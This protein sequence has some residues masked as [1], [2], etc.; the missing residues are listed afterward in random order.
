[1]P[2]LDNL[3]A[4][5]C[6]ASAAD[7]PADQRAALRD[8]GADCAIAFLAGSRSP[9]G[10][11]LMALTDASSNVDKIATATAIIRSTE[12]DDI[13][14]G[15]CT[16]PSSVAVPAAI[17]LSGD[18]ESGEAWSDVESAVLVGIETMVRFGLAINGP[19]ILY[20]GIWPTCFATPLAVAAVAS[21]IW[22]L[23][24][25]Q[26]TH[27][28]SLA[29]MMSAGRTGRFAGAPSGRWIVIKAGVAAGMEAAKAARAGY[30]GDP[31]LLDG[32]WIERA[33]GISIQ[34]DKLDADADVSLALQGLCLKPFSTAR[35]ALAPTQALME[36]LDEGLQAESIQSIIVRVPQNYAAMISQPVNPDNRGSGYVSA[37][38]QMALAALRPAGLWDLDR[39]DIMH[40]PA[41]LAF[42][43]KIS[44]EADPALQEFYPAQWPA[45]IE[46][47]TAG[48]TF[49]RRVMDVRGDANRRLDLA[50][51][52]R[53]GHCLLNATFGVEGAA[54]LWRAASCAFD[55]ASA[56]QELKAVMLAG[57]H[58]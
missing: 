47:V 53:K 40:D 54:A 8:H 16:T 51:R 18:A 10:K 2:V 11:E 46:V 32:D 4:Y 1:M 27:A 6:N 19:S 31:T 20:R 52:Q 35:Q 30:K 13:H 21:R 17:M 38:F 39:S 3:A 44:V 33:Q 23:D 12:V 5:V 14:L 48:H 25:Q 56:M 22:K 34:I 42:A 15:S 55:S 29:L 37:G 24:R 28:L 9:E 43:K 26:T 41:I 45:E 57:F 58:A 50:Q 7:L 49:V 36:L